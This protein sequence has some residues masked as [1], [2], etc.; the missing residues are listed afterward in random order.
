MTTSHCL[1]LC[2]VVCARHQ[3]ALDL[4]KDMHGKAVNPA[5]VLQGMSDWWEGRTLQTR[6]DCAMVSL[7]VTAA[8]AATAVTTLQQ[9]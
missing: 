4:G 9:Q 1:L 2:F 6:L 5:R 8:T 7:A 3:G